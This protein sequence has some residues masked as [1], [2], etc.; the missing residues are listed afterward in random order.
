MGGAGLA[1]FELSLTMRSAANVGLQV[2]DC[3][4][5]RTGGA[6]AL[7]QTSSRIFAFKTAFSFMVRS[8]TARAGLSGSKHSASMSISWRLFSLSL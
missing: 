3:V 6:L 8:L 1:E 2:I 4:F 7:L 5:A